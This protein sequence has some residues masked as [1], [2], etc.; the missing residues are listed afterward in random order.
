M[1]SRRSQQQSPVSRVH[2]LPRVTCASPPAVVVTTTA[3]CPHSQPH[4]AATTAE[5]HAAM[6]PTTSPGQSL[7][8]RRAAH[9]L[10]RTLERN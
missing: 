3:A 1:T 8:V 10:I 7:A 5:V 4:R 9:R 2:H 6:S